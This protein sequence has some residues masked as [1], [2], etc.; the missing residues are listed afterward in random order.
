MILE[1]MVLL[2]MKKKS[3]GRYIYGGWQLSI[4][5]KIYNK[6]IIYKFLPAIPAILYSKKR[7]SKKNHFTF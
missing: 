5:N 2:Q 1:K 7:F 6:I 3:N 4:Y